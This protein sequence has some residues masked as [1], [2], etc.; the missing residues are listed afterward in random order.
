MTRTIARTPLWFGSEAAPLFGWLHHPGVGD[1]RGGVVI[2]PSLGAELV[3]AHP[4]LRDLAERLAGAGF[5]ALRFD[6]PGTGD[7]AG[8]LTTPA[9]VA[10][11]RSGIEQAVQTLRELGCPWVAGVGLR[12]GAALLLS[13]GSAGLDAR[14]LWDPCDGHRFL[15][16][17][18]VRYRLTT[19]QQHDG[20]EVHSVGFVYSEPVAAELRRLTLTGDDPAAAGTPTLALVR[21]GRFPAGLRQVLSAVG[22]VVHEATEQADLLEVPTVE[23]QLPDRSIAAIVDWLAATA[24]RTTAT[25]HTD[26]VR[27]TAH[28]GAVTEHFLELGPLGLFGIRTDPVGEPVGPVAVLLN[29]AAEQH[30]GP[31]RMWVELARSW[32]AAGTPVVRLDLAGLGDSPDRPGAARDQ[33]YDPDHLDDLPEIAAALRAQGTA[34]LLPMGLCSGAYH[35]LE[36][37]IHADAD[38]VIAINPV[39]GLVLPE[40]AEGDTDPRRAAAHSPR[41]LFRRLGGAPQ[42]V[43]L[44]QRLPAFVWQLLDLTGLHPVPTAGLERAVDRGV[45]TLMIASVFDAATYQRRSSKTLRRLEETGRFRLSVVSDIDHSLQIERARRRVST[46]LTAFVAARREAAAA[47]DQPVVELGAQ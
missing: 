9:E 30:I 21:S 38:A 15:R 14:V 1:V 20:D 42:L 23:R 18:L 5:V 37:A 39:L 22:A 4:A 35:A 24:P 32:A 6:Y 3:S 45:D 11:L 29:V 19:G 25:L 17:Q 7:S 34:G 26:G 41:P 31:G 27:N 16:E 33:V 2:C 44:K 28:L 47:V 10:A 40:A 13:L 43:W 8:E 12:I 36:W 46:E